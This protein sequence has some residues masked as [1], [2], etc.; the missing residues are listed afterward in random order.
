MRSLLLTLLFVIAWK[1]SFCQ[2]DALP[3][4]YFDRSFEAENDIS[5]ASYYGT[6]KKIHGNRYE[7]TFFTLDGRKIA[8]GEYLG[9]SLKNRSGLFVRY[10]R[11]GN[12]I[13]S[14]TYRKSLLHGPFLRFYDNGQKAD[15]GN[16]NRGNNYGTW[17]SWYDNGQLKDVRHFEI[18]HTSRG[19]EFSLQTDEYKSWYPDGTLKDSGYYRLN[20]RSG[21]WVE[22]IE[23]GTIRSVG[24]YRNDWK[25]GDW[26]YYDAKGNLLYIR[27]FRKYRYD[28]TGEKIELKKNAQL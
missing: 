26:R 20:E 9:K 15:S 19:L 4:V 17:K 1:A 21:V 2:G 8:M 14:T 18:A 27:R 13:L 7:V 16:V 22:W 10:N 24:E 11:N 3:I 5:F 25:R 28:L 6:P 23:Q 12:I